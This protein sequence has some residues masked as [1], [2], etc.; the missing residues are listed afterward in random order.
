MLVSH[1]A[2][3]PLRSFI[4]TQFLLWVEYSDTLRDIVSLTPNAFYMKK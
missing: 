2:S 1:I 4:D 3:I